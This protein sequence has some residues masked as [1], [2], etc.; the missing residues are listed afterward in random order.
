[1]R[2][3]RLFKHLPTAQALKQ[4]RFLKPFS[5]YLEDHSLWQFNR[6]AVAGG[7]AVGLFFGLLVPFAQ[8]LLAAIAAILFRV[9]LPVAAFSTLVTN[10]FTFP[11]V[12]YFA[13]LVGDWLIAPQAGASASA[14]ETEVEKTVVAQQHF[15]HGWFAPAL[16]WVQTVGPQLVVGLAV[17]AVVG[18]VA[19]YFAVDATWRFLVHKRWRKRRW[20]G[21]Q[22]P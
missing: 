2:R 9:N 20:R 12:Y 15:M 17:L 16:D 4:N 10:P 22:D 8:I 18:A 14:I 3:H 7:V 11:A 5:R 21:R 19:G 6:R 13:Y 1:M